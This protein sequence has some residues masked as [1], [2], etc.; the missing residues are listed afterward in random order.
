MV[1]QLFCVIQKSIT[2][3]FFPLS[4][5]LL[6]TGQGISTL[7]RH[8]GLSESLFSRGSLSFCHSILPCLVCCSLTISPCFLSPSL[9][10][11]P[12]GNC[13][14]YLFPAL[15]FSYSNNFLSNLFQKSLLRLRTKEENPPF[16]HNDFKINIFF[17]C[18][19]Y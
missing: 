12:H 17:L 10:I 5:F 13:Q 18:S 19:S 1:C 8:S 3:S 16:S 6:D 2:F 9:H 11:P 7:L 14:I 4:R 15:F